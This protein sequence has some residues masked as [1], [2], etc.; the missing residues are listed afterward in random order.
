MDTE[1]LVYLS[2]VC[3]G[4]LLGMDQS[5]VVALRIV[6]LS[7]AVL[8]SVVQHVCASCCT[9]LSEFLKSSW[10]ITCYFLFLLELAVG[11][12]NWCFANYFFVKLFA[13]YS[14][15]AI[16]PVL[17]HTGNVTS[18]VVRVSLS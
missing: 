11:V 14:T 12:I 18:R 16:T 13:F 1:S 5:T 3:G 7:T 4:R 9:T 17:R 8:N 15:P 6:R 10:L 2:G